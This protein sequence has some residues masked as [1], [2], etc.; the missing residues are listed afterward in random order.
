[1]NYYRGL[2]V[3]VDT[4]SLTSAFDDPSGTA[5]SGSTKPIQYNGIGW[6]VI[7]EPDNLDQIAVIH[8]GKNYIWNGSVKHGLMIQHHRKEM[9][10]FIF[11]IK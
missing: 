11:I 3:L 6:N 7:K 2:R 10:A 1:M 5:L 8:E 4:G 9:I